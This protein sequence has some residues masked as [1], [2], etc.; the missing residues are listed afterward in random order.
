VTLFLLLPSIIG[1]LKQLADMGE[2]VQ[3]ASGSMQRATQ[4]LDEPVDIEDKPDAVDLPPIKEQIEF[5][6]IRFGYEPD[7]QILNGLNL[8]I[9]HGT[10]LAVV[11]PSGSGKSTVV[12]LLLRFWDPDDGRVLVDGHDIKDIKI[13]S[14]RD[15]IGIV[16]QET[17]IFNTTL[18]DNIG[19]ARPGATDEEIEAA[20][21]QAQL[22]SL[23]ESLPSGYDTVLGERGVRMS[24]GQRQRL[25][26]ARAL[27]RDPAILIFDEAT[28][29]L[30]ARTEAEIRETISQVVGGRTTISITHRLGIAA[31]ADLIAVLDG[32]V[33][34]ELGNHKE[35]VKAGG[36]YQSLYEEQMGSATAGGKPRLGPE[37]ARLKTVPMFA[38]LEGNTLADL[39]DRLLLEKFAAG[40]DI[41]RQGDPGEKLYIITR[42]QADVLVRNGRG[43]RRVNTVKTGDY[44]GDYALL[45][46]E[47]RTATVRATAPMEVYSLAKDD[48]TE[49]VEREKKLQKKI[50]DFVAQRR[51]AFAAAAE[52]AGLTAE[53]GA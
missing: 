20:A 33:V 5:E 21:D 6:D 32:G 9:P 13:S 31:D 36:L 4:I 39:A 50:S 3:T 34:A 26:I 47:E 43:E 30:D 45:T 12:N 16:F 2:V 7:R 1:P 27:L 24:G 40:E 25:A 41:V 15:Q 14:L 49:L 19:M 10:N 18:R 11:G 28:S 53:A 23:V 37:A 42:G 17:F 52:A 51:A 35:L 44:F 46:G 48:F 29:A 22:Q 8:T 38:D